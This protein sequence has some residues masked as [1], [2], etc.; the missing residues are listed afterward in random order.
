MRSVHVLGSP[1][2][3]ETVC[4]HRQAVEAGRLVLVHVLHF[5]E[6]V[7]ESLDFGV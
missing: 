3:P 1:G 2:V 4:V 6:P 5:S 7:S